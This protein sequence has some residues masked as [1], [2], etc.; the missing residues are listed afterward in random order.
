MWEI[1]PAGGE[2]GEGGDQDFS[3]GWRRETFG[4]LLLN[5]EEDT[6]DD[7]TYLRICRETGRTGD[8]VERLLTLGR[9]DEARR[10]V[11]QTSDYALL[12][13]VDVFS[14]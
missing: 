6:L 11:A 8:V 1:L 10:E 4:G 2:R 3:T 9:V 12:E 5:L 13:L 7:E 14:L